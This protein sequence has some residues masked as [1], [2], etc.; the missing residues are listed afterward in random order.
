MIE[1][2]FSLDGLEVVRRC[3]CKSKYRS[4]YVHNIVID[5]E[6]SAFCL[7]FRAYTNLTNAAIPAE[8]IIQVFPCNLVVEVFY[9]QDPIGTRWKLCLY[10]C[11][12]SEAEELSS[13][14]D[15]QPVLQEP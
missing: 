13:E 12:F 4:T 15:L 1:R 6:S 2:I 7:L 3:C 11:G 10:I 5:N 8:Q 14:V 9:K